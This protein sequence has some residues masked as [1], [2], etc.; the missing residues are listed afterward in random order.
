MRKPTALA[1]MAFSYAGTW[2][3][4]ALIVATVIVLGTLLS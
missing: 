4:L 3:V 2:I 1:I